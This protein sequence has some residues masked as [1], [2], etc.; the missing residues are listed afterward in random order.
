MSSRSRSRSPIRKKSAPVLP[1]IDTK[2]PR[3]PGHKHSNSFNSPTYSAAMGSSP[4]FG[5]VGSFYRAAYTDSVGHGSLKHKSHRK[6]PLPR[7]GGIRLKKNNRKNNTKHK[8]SMVPT[9]S[10]VTT[11]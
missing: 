1:K 2:R 4:R 10:T 5:G 8:R 7:F 9:L 3:S 6:P 11:P